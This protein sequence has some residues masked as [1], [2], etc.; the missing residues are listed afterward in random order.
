M[1]GEAPCRR[2]KIRSTGTAPPRRRGRQLHRPIGP[3]CQPRSG[4]PYTISL[5]LRIARRN[6][7][8]SRA[9]LLPPDTVKL[10]DPVGAPAVTLNRSET[11]LG[12]SSAPNLSNVDPVRVSRSSTCSRRSAIKAP[13]SSSSL[14]TCSKSGPVCCDTNWLASAM[15]L[16]TIKATTTTAN[17]AQTKN[18]TTAMIT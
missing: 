2:Q 8:R 4:L 6:R 10:K 17:N 13:C 16:L 11:V 18:T 3:P 5:T 7:C 9:H 15:S 1:E 12:G 14:W